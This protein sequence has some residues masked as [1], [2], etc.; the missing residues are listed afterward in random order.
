MKKNIQ[1]IPMAVVSVHKYIPNN[2]SSKWASH[3]SNRNRPFFTHVLDYV[4]LNSSLERGK[5]FLCTTNVFVRKKDAI[6]SLQFS[7]KFKNQ[8][9]HDHFRHGLF[10]ISLF[11]FAALYFKSCPF[12]LCTWFA[13]NTVRVRLK[14]TTLRLT[15]LSIGSV[16]HLQWPCGRKKNHYEIIRHEL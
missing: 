8:S 4:L 5:N 9:V 3:L 7:F 14:S 10:S 1:N 12:C 6:L 11:H 15:L 2:V 13:W 16:S